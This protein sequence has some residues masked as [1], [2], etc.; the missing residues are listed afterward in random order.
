M[1]VKNIDTRIKYI[2]LII[3]LLFLIIFLKVFYIQ[4]ISYQKLYS[5][6]DDLISREL[7]IVAERGKILDR[8]GNVLAT[9]ITTSSIMLIPS[10]IK[11]KEKTAEI[12][13]SIIDVSYDEMLKHVNKN[14]SIERIQKKGRNLDSETADKIAKYNLKGV[15]LIKESKRYYPYDNLLSHVLGFTGSDN[16]GLSGVELLYDS[17]LAGEDGYIKYYSDAKGNRLEMSEVYE[18]SSKGMDITLTIDIDIQKSIERELS[19]INDMFNPDGAWALAM[20]PSTGEILGMASIPSFNPNKYQNYSEE[21][22]NRNLAIW[23]TYEPGST[24]KNVTPL[25]SNFILKL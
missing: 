9:N 18:E 21:V 2:L 23:K 22:I 11:D 8:N 10:Q 6:E 7:P 4:V 24:F 3:V 19:N 14:V 17:Y 12:L 15:Y 5:M 25:F 16:I 20:N 13:S 1:F